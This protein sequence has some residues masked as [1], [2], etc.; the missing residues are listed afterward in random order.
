MKKC[1][2]K[3][4]KSLGVQK[5]YNVTMKSDQHNYAIY[6]PKTSFS[7]ISK[8]SHSASYAFLAYQTAFLKVHYPLEFMCSLLSSELGSGDK[9][10]KLNSYWKETTRMGLCIKR[11]DLNLSKLHFTIESGISDLTGKPID[12]IR[13]PFTVLDG[14]GNNA[15][16]EIVSKQ[17]FEDLKDFL[18]RVNL[19]KVD[20]RVFERLVEKEC[21]PDSWGSMVSHRIMDKYHAIKAEIDKEKKHLKKSEEYMS[22]FDGGLFDDLGN[23]EISM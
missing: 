5:T 23:S 18:L 3:S 1:K 22:Q 16:A 11:T 15:A 8:N 2:V 12:Y 7:V 17:P 13:A 9:N 19:T 21:L 4:I 20:V 14:V 10:K 6:D